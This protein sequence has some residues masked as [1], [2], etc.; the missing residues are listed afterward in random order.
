MDEIPNTWSEARSLLRAVLRP[1]VA[2]QAVWRAAAINPD[3]AVVRREFL[4]FLHQLLV[5]DRELLRK[6]VPVSRLPQWAASESLAFSQ[7]YANQS[8]T[9][10]I[11]RRP[12]GIWEVRGPDAASRLLL[13]GW[14]SFFRG[15][16]SGTPLVALPETTTLFIGGDGSTEWRQELVRLA[17]V[18]WR[19]AEHPL[20]PM[21]Y[22]IDPKGTVIPW[23]PAPQDGSHAW[24]SATRCAFA[25]ACYEGLGELIEDL[26]SLPSIASRWNLG[27]AF[28]VGSV[29]VAV[30]PDDAHGNPTPY[31]FTRWRPDT[32]VIPEVDVVVLARPD[33]KAMI[34]VPWSAFDSVFSKER[35][36]LDGLPLALWPVANWA[37]ALERLRPFAL[38]PTTLAA[39]DD[40]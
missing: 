23:S 30:G 9:E 26:Y 20:S 18:G 40:E 1:V 17:A 21:L 12:D 7:A 19:E 25:Q 10:G 3:K 32:S 31:T 24:V 38:D 5:V 15:K 27:E 39:K 6:F 13:P 36:R 34:A 29:E 16:V 28:R 33:D 35:P 8:P 14:L 4:P 37:S 2:P 22:S 11:E